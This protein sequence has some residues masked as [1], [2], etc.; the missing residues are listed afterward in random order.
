MTTTITATDRDIKVQYKEAGKTYNTD[1]G[2]AGSNSNP[3]DE[4]TVAAGSSW[5]APAGSTIIGQSEMGDAPTQGGTPEDFQVAVNA[6]V[7][8]PSGTAVPGGQGGTPE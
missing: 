5:T 7:N 6:P 3:F 1:V 2:D 8:T 4:V